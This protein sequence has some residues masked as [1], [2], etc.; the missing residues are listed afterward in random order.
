[1]HHAIKITIATC[2]LALALAACAPKSRSSTAALE[3]EEARGG[4]R[5]T[6]QIGESHQGARETCPVGI[7]GLRVRSENT[8]SGGALVFTTRREDAIPELRQRVASFV[9]AHGEAIAR[10]EGGAEHLGDRSQLAAAN[11]RA[12]DV[13]NGSRLEVTPRDASMIRTVRRELRQ[14]A[15]D[16]AEGRC[17]ISMRPED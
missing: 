11:V 3:A 4:E 5:V 13:P 7:A 1:M 17:P 6:A 10:T 9:S 12:V 8:R 2:G 14:D 15:R 16:M